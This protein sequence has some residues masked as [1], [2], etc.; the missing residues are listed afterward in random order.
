MILL[1]AMQNV[2]ALSVEADPTVLGYSWQQAER[3]NRSRIEETCSE[4]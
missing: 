4:V 3:I 1:R 2:L